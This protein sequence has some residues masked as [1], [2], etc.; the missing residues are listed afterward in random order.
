MSA[1]TATAADDLRDGAEQALALMRRQGFEHAQVS[2]SR[3]RRHELCVAHNEASLLRSTQSNKLQLTGLL[4]GRRADIEGSE[5]DPHG[6]QA[7]VRS[8]WA[9]VAAAPQDAANALSAGQSA[10]VT[11]GDEQADTGALADAMRQLLDWRAEHTPSVMLEEALAG[12][13]HVRSCTLT[14]STSCS[15]F[16]GLMYT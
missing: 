14:T 12:H 10:H 16:F 2:A 7:L 11:R 9:N 5:F 3:Q 4:D 15:P 8:L 6:M 13:T 1:V